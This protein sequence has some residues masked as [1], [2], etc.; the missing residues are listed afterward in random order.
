ML[1]RKVLDILKLWRSEPDHKSVLLKGQRQVGKTYIVREFGKTYEHF[2]EFDFIANPNEKSIFEGSLDADALIGKMKLYR[3]PKDF[4]PGSTLIFLDEVQE[5]PRARTALKQFTMDGKYDVIASGSLL[6]VSE[7]HRNESSV[8]VGYETHI[9]M[10]PLDFEEFLWA[11]GIEESAIGHVR[12]S[13]SSYERIDP[14]YLNVF[15]S[16]FREYLIVGGMP[17][18]VQRYVDTKDITSA[19]DVIDNLIQ[20]AMSDINRYNEG[21]DKIKVAECFRSIPHQLDQTNK[22][23]MYSRI[24]GGQSRRSAE[25]YM[26]N[27]LWIKAAGYGIISYSLC[28]LEL[29]M[30]EDRSSFR[31]YLSDTGMLCHMYGNSVMRALLESDYSV[32]EGAIAENIVAICLSKTGSDLMYYNKNSGKDRMELDFVVD[33]GYGLTAIAVKTGKDRSSVSMNK[34]SAFFKENRVMFRNGD[35]CD[36]DGIRAYPIFAAAFIDDIRPKGQE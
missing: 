23:F 22:K 6:G 30:K 10:S 11:A 28:G 18:A 3:D 13:I 24:S 21:V 5:C 26:D 16:K 1:R 36:E 25:R 32:N 4:V 19:H 27:V 7:L 9:Q 20:S 15:E 33:T 8:P 17:E 31:I 14:A 34:A 12:G 29:P 2:I 35:V